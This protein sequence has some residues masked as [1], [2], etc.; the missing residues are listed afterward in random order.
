LCQKLDREEE[1]E[2]YFLESVNGYRRVLGKDHPD[3]LASESAL[4]GL[5]MHLGKLGEA[6][7]V[8]L[9]AYEGMS[10]SLGLDAP[11]TQLA[12]YYLVIVTARL[13][14]N[15]EAEKLAIRLL[16][17]T[18]VNSSDYK[19]HEDMLLQIQK[20]LREIESD[21]LSSTDN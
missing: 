5:Y 6:E 18:P 15:K 16:E 21:G 19:L 8:L 3:T 12:L 11:S 9:N 7:P 17:H 20:K 4:G 1:A 2:S 13:G 14:K 10:A